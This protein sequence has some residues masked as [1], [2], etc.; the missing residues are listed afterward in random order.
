MLIHDAEYTEADYLKK[1][2]WGHTVYRDALR[3]ALGAGV[4]K[5]GLFHHNQERT[6]SEL[7][8]IVEDCRKAILLSGHRLDCFALE[9]EMEISL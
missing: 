1:K 6:D 7:D 5:L 2:A 9:Q 3:L 8:S 4:K